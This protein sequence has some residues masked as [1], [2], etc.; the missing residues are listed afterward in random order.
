MNHNTIGRI[1][2][3]M[4]LA[5]SL[6]SPTS[7]RRSPG[8]VGPDGKDPREFSWAIDTISYPG[9]YQTLMYRIWG[10][11]SADIY[12]VGGNDQA[13]GKMYHY[14]GTSWQPVKLITYEGGLIPGTLDLS[15]VFGFSKSDI[16]A[17]G[18]RMYDNPVPPPL[19]LD[20]SIVIHFD[21]QNWTE[22]PLQRGRQLVGVWGASPADVWTGG[23]QGTLFHIESGLSKRY[24]S[25]DTSWFSRFAGLSAND[26]YGL[27]YAWNSESRDTTFRYLWHWDGASWSM[28]DQFPE[29][30]DLPFKFGTS[31]IRAIGGS[32]YTVGAGVYQRVGTGWERSLLVAPAGFLGDIGGPSADNLIVAGNSGAVYHFNGSD[33]RQF[34]Q[35]VSPSIHYSSVWYDGNEVFVV[36]NDGYKSY[37]LH[38]K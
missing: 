19:I 20:S 37:V 7:C 30:Y 22:I 26:V 25:T 34:S 3:I 35:F 28:V 24:S 8:P 15:D 23:V 18:G 6:L 16:Y 38:G 21:G 36:G 17:V 31:S 11:S 13:M 32:I 9:S 4:A 14:D 29:R 27:S 5:G 12:I 10:S 2:T 33:W 1:F